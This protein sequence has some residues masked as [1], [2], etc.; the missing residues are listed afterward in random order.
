MPVLRPR[1]NR[2]TL[3]CVTIPDIMISLWLEAKVQN[4]IDIDYQMKTFL[5]F[6]YSEN[7]GMYMAL[8]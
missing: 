7:R 8:L 2:D 6:F 3:L 4:L 5:C 1:D